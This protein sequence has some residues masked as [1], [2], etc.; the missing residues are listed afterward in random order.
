L[1]DRAVLR[2]AAQTGTPLFVSIGGA[3]VSEIG[4][5]VDTLDAAGCTSFVLVHSV[6]VASPHGNGPILEL[7]TLRH[8]FGVP[9]GLSSCADNDAVAGA[10]VALGACAIELRSSAGS[11]SL[12]EI[13]SHIRD[14][15]SRLPGKSVR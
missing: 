8:A 10:A 2:H 13:I 1:K 3:G 12:S 11:Y 9:V 14:L 15:E 6:D 5:G 7:S 4:M